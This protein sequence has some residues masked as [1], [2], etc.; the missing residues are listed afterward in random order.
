MN[1]P[2]GRPR[3]PLVDVNGQAKVRAHQA[4]GGAWSTFKGPSMSQGTY[5]NILARRGKYANKPVG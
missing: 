5:Y 1:L 3:P 2:I 4:A